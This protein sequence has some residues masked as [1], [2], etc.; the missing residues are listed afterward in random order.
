MDMS[1]PDSGSSFQQGEDFVAARLSIDVPSDG[2]ATLRELSQEIERYRV[3]AEAAARAQD[4]F[5]QY[6]TQS[7]EVADRAA[8]AQQNL[9]TALQRTAELQERIASGSSTAGG[10]TVPQGYVDPF[11]NAQA[12]HGGF[13]SPNDMTA[14]NLDSVQGQI[15]QLRNT[16]PRTYLNMQAARG[17]LRAGDLP[18]AT[19]DETQ[20]HQAASRV[21]TRDQQNAQRISAQNSANDTASLRGSIGRGAGMAQQVLNEVGAGGSLQGLGGLAA[22]ALTSAAASGGIQGGALAGIARYAGGAGLGLGGLL[23]ANGLLQKGGEVVQGY[24]NMGS[25]RGGGAMEGFGT[26]MAIRAMAMNPLISTEQSRQI[27]QSALTE[28][29]TGKT[30]DTVTGFISHNLTEMNMSVNESVELL[31]KNVNEGGQSIAGLA[32][33]LGVLRGLSKDGVRSLPELSAEFQ[34]TTSNLVGAGMSGADAE[35]AALLAGQMFPDSQNLK[36]VGGKIANGMMNPQNLSMIQAFG[37]VNVPK[38]LSPFAMPYAMSGDQLVQGGEGVL[39][40]YA[41][42]IYRGAGSPP[43]GS[44]AYFN[45]MAS[46]GQF[47]ARFGIAPNEVKELF[48]KLLRGEDITGGASERVADEMKEQT[49]VQER[50]FWQQWGGNLADTGE[51]LGDVVG[52]NARTVFSNL[53]SLLSGHWSEIPKRWAERGKKNIES[54][55]APSKRSGDYRIP[56]LDQIMAEYGPTGIEILDENQKSVKFNP[57]DRGQMDKISEGAYTWRPKGSTGRGVTLSETP[58][59]GENF[60]DRVTQ[61]QGSVQLGLTPDAAKLLQPQGGNTIRLTPHEQRANQ[62]YG[63]AMP[64]NAPP[65]EGPLTRGR[66]GW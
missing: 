14:V 66:S 32:A 17:N 7:A 60:R 48:P 58:Q 43:E 52:G 40:K 55:N 24:A 59:A 3:G 36:D 57:N 65:G 19:P 4:N 26:E 54:W 27:I 21:A 25:I 45:V 10:I 13:R 33:N 39:R 44:A 31:R 8:G 38:G 6:L 61:V 50:G 2:I 22:N 9:I 64:N 20:L 18:A 42:Q 62:S 41:Q 53:G 1:S 56:M 47:A 51:M 30:F 15:E 29:Y 5:T 12:G 63:D 37:G 34:A 28:G 35:R 23:A 11:G 49:S 46:F 16:D